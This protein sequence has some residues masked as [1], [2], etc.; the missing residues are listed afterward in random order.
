MSRWLRSIPRSA[1]KR[2]NCCAA[3]P[4]KAASH[5]SVHCISRI[6]PSIISNGSS[7]CAAAKSFASER[8]RAGWTRRSFFRRSGKESEM[9]LIGQF[10]P[11]ELSLHYLKAALVPLEE[12]LAMAAGGILLAVILGMLGALGVGAGLPGS[13]AAFSALAAIRSFPD[14]TLAILCVVVIGIGPAAGM[15]AIAV[16]YAAA[17]GKIFSDLFRSPHPGAPPAL[18]ATGASR[19]SVALFGLLPLR[20]KDILSYGTYEFES[21]LRCSVIVGAVGGGGIGTELI[22]T[23]NALDFRRAT[24]LILLLIALIAVIDTCA[25]QVKKKPSLLF[26]VFPL[27]PSG[28]CRVRPIFSL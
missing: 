27:P 3:W 23:I 2:W 8:A 13:K 25:R 28:S 16:F 17:I 10:F 24:P 18:R 26:L 20:S 12:T 14:L 5:C 19:L 9:R 11:P 21:A 6:W 22:G 15:L 1:S 7:K 4:R